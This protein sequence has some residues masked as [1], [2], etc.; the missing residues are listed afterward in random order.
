LKSNFVTA[1]PSHH[2]KVKE[3]TIMNI[4][5]ASAAS[6]VSAKMIR[7][8][9]AI[10]LLRPAVRRDNSYRDYGTP[11]VHELQFIG[12]AR[13]LGFSIREIS[14]LLA[15]WR[16][17]QRPSREVHQIATAHL[18]ELESRAAEIQVMASTLRKLVHGCHGDDRPD[19]PI[20]DDLGGA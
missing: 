18:E 20:L 16:D 13:K 11:D 6:G 14:D 15:L 12:R 4:G 5:A 10:G 19:C 1:T 9:E 17:K 8:Y 7:H 3:L 2:G